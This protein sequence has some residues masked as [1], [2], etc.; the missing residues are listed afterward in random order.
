METPPTHTHSPL[1][2]E[3][4]GLFGKARQGEA[5]ETERR[6]RRMTAKDA[7]GHVPNTP[8]Q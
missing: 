4:K 1:L 3:F 5:R 7:R 6:E 2:K 8:R